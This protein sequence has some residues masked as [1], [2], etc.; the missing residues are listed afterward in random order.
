[1][2]NNYQVIRERNYL[3]DNMKAVMLFLVAF[4]HLLDVYK[5]ETGL[6][7]CTMKYIYLFHMPMFAFVTGYFTKNVEKARNN[8]FNKSLIP[9]I[10]LQ[11]CYCI[12]A[13]IMIRIGLASYNSDVFS[14][15]LV[16]PTSAFYYLLA[17]FFWKLF[18]KDLSKLRHPFIFSVFMGVCISF[19][20]DTEFHVGY[21]AVFSLLPF[22]VLGMICKQEYIEKI[23]KMP[24]FAAIGI[25]LIGIL[26]AI[27]LPYAIHSIRMTYAAC[28]FSNLEGA[29]YRLVF[30][31]IAILLGIALM[32]IMPE[33]KTFFSGIGTAA[34]AVYGG[35]TFLSP[36]GYVI[37]H[38]LFACLNHRW[39]NFFAMALYS[40]VLVWICS[41]PIFS[42]VLQWMID[43][44]TKIIKIETE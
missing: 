2:S 1:M 23:R 7:I 10:I 20:K 27:Y 34:L 9:Y 33:K 36:H 39:L 8:A 12:M 6:E 14:A 16:L 28:G 11:G 26:P 4:G 38:R 43:T 21:G 29:F 19:T 3:M 37:I 24:L 44:F 5:G 40:G 30:Y 17:V 25:L 22:F 42:R 41:W 15:S 32:R 35:S 31:I 13:L 18:A